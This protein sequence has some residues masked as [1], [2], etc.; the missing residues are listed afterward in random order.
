MSIL[1]SFSTLSMPWIIGSK[2]SRKE[3]EIANTN[4]YLQFDFHQN[5]SLFL[6]LHFGIQCPSY[7]NFLRHSDVVRR[8]MITGDKSHCAP[9]RASLQLWSKVFT[10]LCSDFTTGRCERL[11]AFEA[12][13]SP[14]FTVQEGDFACFILPN[15]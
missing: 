15:Q 14:K 10:P 7:E 2:K 6:P 9:F 8:L 3:K 11:N 13:C 4:P 12:N 5:L 1:K